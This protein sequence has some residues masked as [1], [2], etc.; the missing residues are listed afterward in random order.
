ML[1]IKEWRMPSEGFI[2]GQ[3]NLCT[4]FCLEMAIDKYNRNFHSQCVTREKSFIATI[5]L[6][7]HYVLDVVLSALRLRSIK[8]E[9][10]FPIILKQN[11][12]K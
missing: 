10:E 2:I 12:E 5:R 7:T 6:I 8:K 3:L 11:S 9:R 1:L 4:A